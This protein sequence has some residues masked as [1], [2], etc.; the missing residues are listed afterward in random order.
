MRSKEWLILAAVTLALSQAGQVVCQSTSAVAE[1]PHI[2][3]NG[4]VLLM[5]KHGMN[6]DAIKA[7]ILSSR[8]NFD[9][10]PPA[11]LD[12]KRRGVPADVL[13]TMTAVPNGPASLPD[14]E[15]NSQK[16][17][18]VQL[19]R[20]LGIQVE[21]IY[22]VSSANIKKGSVIT[23]AVVT[24][25]Y[26]DGVLIVARGALAKAHIL[27]VRRAQVFGRGGM[28]TWALDHV[29]A[30]DGTKIPVQLA[31]KA[32]GTNRAGEAAAGAALTSAIIFPY[33]APAALVWAFK[34]GDDAVLR[35]NKRFSALLT[36]ETEVVG[37]VP[38]KD[39]IKYHYADSVK[40]KTE[41][42][43]T[44]TSFPRLPVRN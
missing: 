19:P 29:V 15:N 2:L 38:D 9:V 31:A 40:Q 13:D 23:F 21:T 20:G 24:P 8:C 28:F 39:R 27:T 18:K 12:L 7:R 37:L 16:T 17:A 33:T 35:G 1:S 25:V 36:N 6:S 44:P 34:K 32:A 41:S 22:P 14:V 30:V 3:R 11:L 26:V 10:F 43:A 5:V 42:S 4:D